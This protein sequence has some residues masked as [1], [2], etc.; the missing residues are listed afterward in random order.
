MLSAVECLLNQNWQV[1]IFW[2][3]AGQIKNIAGKLGIG[4]AGAD[5]LGFLPEDYSLL[6]RLRLTK[7]YDLVFWLSDGSLPVLLGK[8]NI[9][10]F[11]RPFAKVGGNKIATQIKLG[12]INSIVCNSKFTKK[13]VDKEFGIQSSVLYP[14]VDVDQFHPGK[15]E[16]LILAV[17]RFEPTKKHQVLIKAFKMLYTQGL[18]DWR[19]VLIGGSLEK[20]EKNDY[21]SQ[22]KSQAEG[23]PVDIHVN[24]EFSKLKDFYARAKFFW[25]A[26]GYRADSN[27]PD[28]LEHFGITPV[29]A[30][31]SGCVPLVYN[32]GGLT[33]IVRRG[34]GERWTTLK[35]LKIMSLE[36]INNQEKYRDYQKRAISRSK[37]FS[38]QKFCQRLNRIIGS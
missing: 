18:K 22:I 4:T 9:V 34:E 33:E 23:L 26:K 1:D 28:A 16:N 20:P 25:H 29:E 13:F 6:R 12:L 36:L 15:K 24:I 31:A 32:K 8:N 7:S 11:Q 38:K 3:N 30:M 14:P 27:S 35:E 19:L 17:G 10:H 2:D 5:V 37:N 21:I